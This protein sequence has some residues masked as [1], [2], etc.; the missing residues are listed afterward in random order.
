[1]KLI[2]KLILINVL[3]VS[4]LTYSYE[5]HAKKWIPIALKDYSG[6]AIEE[7]SIEV[8]PGSVV[9]ISKFNNEKIDTYHRSIFLCGS[10][11]TY[12]VD[13]RVVRRGDPAPNLIWDIVDRGLREKYNQPQINNFLSKRCGGQ[14]S[15]KDLEV[16]ITLTSNPDEADFILAK[17][18][19]LSKRFVVIWLKSY[20]VEKEEVVISG[21][22]LIVDGKP[23]FVTK[24]LTDRGYTLQSFQY[25]CEAGTSDTLAFVEYDAS[26]KV[27]QSFDFSNLKSS[28]SRLIPGSV[29]MIRFDYA[30]GLR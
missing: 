22:R 19:K 12:G 10:L 18:T 20:K 16:P 11:E 7:T 21:E 23:Y 27:K 15:K 28:P 2:R 14:L 29:G 5:V 30:C 4:V 25:D 24:V 6:F 17:S 13:S 1:M 26:G 8:Y 3:L 9:F